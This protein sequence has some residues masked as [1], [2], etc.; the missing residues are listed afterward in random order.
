MEILL[1]VI[2]IMELI[3]LA[4]IVNVFIGGIKKLK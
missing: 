2:G 1:Y 3:C 4:A